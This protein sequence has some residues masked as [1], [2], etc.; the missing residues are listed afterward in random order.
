M[1]SLHGVAI[2]FSDVSSNVLP[3]AAIF[4]AFARSG[5]FSRKKARFTLLEEKF[6]VVFVTNWAQKMP[7]N[8]DSL[9]HLIEDFLEDHSLKSQFEDFFE[10]VYDVASQERNRK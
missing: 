9:E 6:I 1:R 2:S 4:A 7:S 5:E 3:R 8:D 10:S